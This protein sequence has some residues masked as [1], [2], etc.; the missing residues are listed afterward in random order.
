[1]SKNIDWSELGFSYMQTD[2]HVIC[3]Y[4]NG[5]WSKPQVQTDP[6]INMHIAATP[7]HY[8]QACFEGMKAFCRKDGSIAIFR[9]DANARRM[10]DTA[11]RIVMQE[12]PEAL[13]TEAVRLAVEKNIDYVP[14]Y[15]TGAS[16]YIR[17][18]L[19]GTSPRIGLHPSDDYV[20]IIMVMPVGKYYKGGMKP[21]RALVQ[22][23][24]DRAAPKGVGGVKVAGNY[25]AGMMGDKVCKDKGY[26]V[27]L[28]LDS[29]THTYIDEFGTSNFFGITKDGVYV[30]PASPSILPSIT[31]G[32]LQ[33]L[34]KDLGMKVEK[35][36]V[37]LDE[38]GNFA[39][40]AACGTAAI[41][42]PVYSVT[43]GETVYTF[44]DP[45]TPGAGIIRLFNEMQGI[46]Y[47]EK[48]D[49]HGWMMPI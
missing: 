6:H 13:F 46:Q 48:D 20:L 12:P 23:E 28:Y 38:L 22:E 3:T 19:F 24:F 26:A 5:A 16:L 49:R 40:V 30:T 43:R 15:G 47:G 7:L 36:P 17:P 32:S 31:N 41:V 27:P 37:R 44:G 39:E 18:V 25:A 34:A 4:E 10:A 8:G 21:V 45:E 2:A 42:T 29:A 35:R 9:P 11:R 33:I 1:M 14:P